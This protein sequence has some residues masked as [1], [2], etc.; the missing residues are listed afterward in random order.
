[1]QSHIHKSTQ[2]RNLIKNMYDVQSYV[3]VHAYIHNI[4]YST[5]FNIC[6]GRIV[7]K[8]YYNF[9]WK[10]FP[11]D[12]LIAYR[13]F[14]GTITQLDD[15]LTNSIVSAPTPERGNQIMLDIAM[16][17]V[18]KDKT[19]MEFYYLVEEIIDN[20]KLS[21]IMKVFRNGKVYCMRM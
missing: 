1:M 6:T 7:L 10:S 2:S 16:I 19:L 3:Y 5:Y 9:L 21:K 11:E 13:R 12:H 4:M 20:P 14:S 18:S 15:D 17:G 8:K